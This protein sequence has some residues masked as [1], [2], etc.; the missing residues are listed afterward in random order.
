MAMIGS[1][2]WRDAHGELGCQPTRK[3]PVA[4]AAP[5]PLDRIHVAAQNRAKREARRSASPQNPRS[6][7][8]QHAEIGDTLQFLSLMNTVDRVCRPRGGAG[9]DRAASRDHLR[10]FTARSA[11]CV[12][13]RLEIKKHQALLLSGWR[14]NVLQGTIAGKIPADWAEC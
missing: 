9:K 6:R 2:A 12:Q 13:L 7:G 5:V 14:Y 11:S 1:T 10:L 8:P 4:I 3:L